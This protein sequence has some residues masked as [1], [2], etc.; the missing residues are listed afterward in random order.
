[1][2]LNTVVALELLLA[3]AVVVIIAAG[4]IYLSVYNRR[5]QRER[6]RRVRT[7]NVPAETARDE[8]T[9][10]AANRT[11]SRRRRRE[12]YKSMGL[13][14]SEDMKLRLYSSAEY[15]SE[16]GGES[17]ALSASGFLAALKAY[18]MLDGE[19]YD[20]SPQKAAGVLELPNGDYEVDRQRRAL[21]LRRLPPGLPT[22]ARDALPGPRYEVVRREEGTGE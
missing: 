4:A 10:G 18:R 5:G 13:E 9:D 2:N 12:F 19:W 17:Y 1:M 16:L 20:Y 8:P 7:G 21:L 22:S 15:E 14:T 6:S 3:V 11:T